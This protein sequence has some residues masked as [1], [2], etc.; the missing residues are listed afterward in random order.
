MLHVLFVYTAQL[1]GEKMNLPDVEVMMYKPSERWSFW[2]IHV[3]MHL[4]MW[5]VCGT[6]VSPQVMENQDKLHNI[7]LQRLTV[8]IADGL[9]PKY[10]IGS[11]QF[12][13]YLFPQ[14]RGMWVH[15]GD[16]CSQGLTSV[17]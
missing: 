6:P 15:K 2:F 14:D 3:Q 12:G 1:H 10:M 8:R 13:M 16:L 11:D 7:T 17:V 4:S 5:K 9:D